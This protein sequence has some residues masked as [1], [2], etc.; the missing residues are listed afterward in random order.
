MPFLTR[1]G[2]FHLFYRLRLV[3]EEHQICWASSILSDNMEDEDSIYG[4]VP[5]TLQS[6][7]VLYFVDFHIHQQLYPVTLFPSIGLSVQN[8]VLLINE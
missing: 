8:L 1:R 4:M 6:L 7:F 5:L 3:A 2:L